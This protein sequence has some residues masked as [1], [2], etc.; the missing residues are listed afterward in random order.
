L[1]S[2]RTRF[3]PEAIRTVFFFALD[4]V[5]MSGGVQVQTEREYISAD[6]AVCVTAACEWKPP[7]LSLY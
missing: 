2:W 6:C 5:A 3:R 7:W 1:T 4:A